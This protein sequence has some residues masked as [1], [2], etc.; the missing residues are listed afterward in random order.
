MQDIF[1]DASEKLN[2]GFEYEKTY[3]KQQAKD[4]YNKAIELLNSALNLPCD[5]AKSVATT[6]NVQKNIELASNRLAK[7]ERT[8]TKTKQPCIV[9][10]SFI[11]KSAFNEDSNIKGD[12]TLI[13]IIT[14]EMISTN[15]IKFSDIAG[16][17]AAKQALK[18]AVIWP[19]LTGDRSPP[20]GILLFGPPGNGK[21]LLAKALAN[22]SKYKFFNISA[23]SLTSKWVG[24]GEKLVRT[25]FIVAKHYQ[26]S[27]IFMGE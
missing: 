7:L 27:I 10:A 5:N 21:T 24:E 22:E 19:S 13:K 6:L 1:C 25:L 4:C 14:S 11:Y 8:C 15:K 17:K 16:Q 18:E 3:N 9:Q 26:P 20:N 12:P 23:S 2:E